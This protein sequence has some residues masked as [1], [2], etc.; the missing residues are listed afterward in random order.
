MLTQKIRFTPAQQW[1]HIK[2]AYPSACGSLNRGIMDCRLWLQPTPISCDYLARI[3]YKQGD[4]PR[5]WIEEPNFNIIASGKIIPH[6][7]DRKKV[8]L[9]LYHPKY[10]PWSSEKS[11]SKTIIPWASLWLFF[12][13]DWLISGEWRGGGE[14][15]TLKREK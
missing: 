15:S 11:I 5:V 8:Q 2:G 14:H 13:E 12:F 4:L 3:V 7:Y 1:A 10:N 6:L 9:C